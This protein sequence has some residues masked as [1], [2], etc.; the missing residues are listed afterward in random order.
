MGFEVW[1]LW[2]RVLGLGFGVW[3]L[4]FRVWGLEYLALRRC[5]TR[6]KV[7]TK[8]QTTNHKPQTTNHKPQTTNHKPQTPNHKPALDGAFDSDDRYDVPG[9]KGLADSLGFRV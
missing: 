7:K 2:F 1:G 9:A 6:Q 4:W 8:P 5:R 3:G